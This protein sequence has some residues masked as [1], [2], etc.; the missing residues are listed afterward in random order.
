MIFVSKTLDRK[1]LFSI[2]LILSF[3]KLSSLPLCP[4]DHTTVWHDCF[5]SY[6]YDG[7]EMYS[8][9]WKDNLYHGN[10]VFFI[11]MG[12]DILGNGKK[13]T[14]TVKVLIPIRMEMFTWEIGKMVRD[15]EKVPML[16]KFL[17][18]KVIFM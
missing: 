14:L 3:S 18:G 12:I 4:E 7:G 11:R 13:I 1:I 6:L 2:F 16:I 5:G 8:G 15:M 10:G 17:N 9:D